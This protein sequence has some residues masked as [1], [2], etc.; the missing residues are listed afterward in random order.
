MTC[1]DRSFAIHCVMIMDLTVSVCYFYP[2]L[3]ALHNLDPDSYDIPM[4]IRCTY[5]KLQ[6]DGV[7]LLGND[8]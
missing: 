1:D 7:Y 3:I 2:R 5:E 8:D 4:P 6:D